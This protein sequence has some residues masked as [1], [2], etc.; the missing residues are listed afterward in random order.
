MKWDSYVLYDNKDNINNF[1]NS[2]YRDR[3]RVNVLFVLGM[4][5]DPRMNNNI[6]LAINSIHCDNFICLAIDFPTHHKTD[7]DIFYELNCR[8]LQTLCKQKNISI[9]KISIDTTK[10]WDW[11]I[12]DMLVRLDGIDIDGY[13]DIIVDVSSIPRAFYYNII[14]LFNGKT[15][16]DDKNLFVMVSENVQID[17]KIN[18]TRPEV[19]LQPLFGFKAMLGREAILDRKNILIP[20]IGES[21][22]RILESIFNDF[23]PSDV[24]PVLPFPSADPR[25]SDK[26]LWEHQ[27]TLES[28][29]QVEPQSLMYAHER[30]PFEL[31][32]LLT[33]LIENYRD[34]MKP[35][36]N[37]ICFG[38]ALLTSKLLSLGVLLVSLENE[39][40]I[41]IYNVSSTD[42]IIENPDEIL[43]LN[44]KSEPFLMWIN[45]DAY[46]E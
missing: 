35:I 12:K 36:S 42:Y 19:G 16:D 21:S 23:K 4:G 10:E 31:Y 9:I 28:K 26:L 8:N 24:C 14:K 5:F 27:F 34:T 44:I 32:R 3:K 6:Q 45:G 30:N 41:V 33:T 46:K 38:F 37:H 25:R 43:D 11:R 18:K 22:S 7:G 17:D 2:Y 13:S 15:K 40:D 1:W 29:L 20:L 39:D